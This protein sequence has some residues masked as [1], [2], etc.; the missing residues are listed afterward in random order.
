MR[1]IRTALISF[2]ASSLTFFPMA[3]ISAEAV[4]EA[5]ANST[6]SNPGGLSVRTG[7]FIAYATA[8]PTGPNPGG[9]ALVLT[10]TASAQY[11]YV[12]NTGSIDITK[13]SIAITYDAGPGPVTLDR[14]DA[15]VAFSALN[16]CATGVKTSMTITSG[17]MTLAVAPN[18]WFAFELDPKKNVLPTIS[19]SVSSGEI[20]SAIITNS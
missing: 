2:F 20:R 4:P 11:F 19:V 17:V 3:I 14:C 10:K 5:I 18:S 7:S 1:L 16:T 9:S 6:A 15:G 8:S 13:F 12:R